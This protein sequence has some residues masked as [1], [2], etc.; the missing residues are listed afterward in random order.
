MYGV[1][2]ARYRRYCIQEGC[3]FVPLVFHDFFT[4]FGGVRLFVFQREPGHGIV[5][6]RTIKA[7]CEVIGIK[8]IE[9][10][11]DGS[12]NYLHI[13]KAF[14]LGLMRQRT[15]QALA[16]EKGLYLVELKEENLLFPKVCGENAKCFMSYRICANVTLGVYGFQCALRGVSFQEGVAIQ[17]GV[18]TKTF[19][20]VSNVYLLNLTK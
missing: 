17:R 5:A 10:V 2:N 18:Y 4:Q 16:D 14:F 19:P 8:D 9:V 3:F 6:H 1:M 7:A 13:I 15:H 20:T 12:T 11:L